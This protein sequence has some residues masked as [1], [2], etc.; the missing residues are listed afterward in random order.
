MCALYFVNITSPKRS[1]WS[2]VHSRDCD[3]Q[4]TVTSQQTF[5]IGPFFTPAVPQR[6]LT[7]WYSE[8]ICNKRPATSG[9]SCVPL[10]SYGWFSI[11][12]TGLYCVTDQLRGVIFKKKPN[13]YRYF[14][15]YEVKF[16]P[17]TGRE[18]P[19]EEWRCTCTISLTSALDENGWSTPRP[20]L[21]TPG[22]MTRCPLC[23]S[24]GGL[25]GRSGRMSTMSPP[26][27]FDP[28][29]VQPLASR[30]TYWATPARLTVYTL[31]FF[32]SYILAQFIE[33]A[34][35]K[36]SHFFRSLCFKSVQ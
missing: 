28:S 27:G 9:A 10:Y 35:R 5:I 22:E 7:W 26:P 20:V 21:F 23:T 11:T 2:A 31:S 6:P 18:S 14:T 29:I 3:L 25:Q 34:I 4:L 36:L 30:Y 33:T 17:R 19:E 16:D 8:L 12:A 1:S 15:A 32:V 13:V 24:L